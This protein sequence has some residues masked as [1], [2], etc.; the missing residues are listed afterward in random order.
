MYFLPVEP[1]YGKALILQIHRRISLQSLAL[2]AYPA[3]EPLVI[4]A[5]P[6]RRGSGAFDPPISEDII[7]VVD[8]DGGN[9][10]ESYGERVGDDPGGHEAPVALS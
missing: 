7:G 10:S 1:I 2:H 5:A 4:G 6:H 8:E 9:V 3:R